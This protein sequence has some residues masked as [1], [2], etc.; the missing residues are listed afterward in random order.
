MMSVNDL[1]RSP[2]SDEWEQALQRY[3]LF[4]QPRNMELERALDALDVR[5]LQNLSPQGWYDFLRDEYF[6]W[7]Y[8][9][10][11]RYAT[12]TIQLR[13]YAEC[14][15]LQELDGIRRQLFNFDLN[16][17]GAGLKTAKKIRGLGTAGA[18]GLLS[19]MYPE[20]F[21]TV[22]QFVVKALREVKNLPEAD[23]LA[24]MTPLNLSVTEGVL[25]I[26]ILK[27]KAKDNN[28]LFGTSIWTPRKIDMVLWT[29]GR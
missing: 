18:S 25:L 26:G 22:D 19:L 20:H 23:A 13:K 2:N 1:W 10:P 4:V 14:N 9:A 15:A 5:R 28:H 6:R 3:W 21:A 11:N 7:K 24:K 12:T 17:V 29:Y 8:T 16:D 27:R